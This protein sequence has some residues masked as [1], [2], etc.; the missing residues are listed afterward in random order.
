MATPITIP[1]NT[2]LIPVNVSSSYKTFTLPV[3]STNPG[4]MIIFKDMFGCSTNSTIRL[5]TIGLDRIEQSNVSSMVLSNNYGAWTFMNDGFT[6]WFQTN[7]YTNTF[8][9][10]SLF[11]NTLRITIG[12]YGTVN[13]V[14]GANVTT[15]VLSYYNA[16]SNS[17][18]VN[19]TVFGD[20]TPG[21]V[22]Y[23]WITYFPPGSGTSKV[24]APVQEGGTFFFNTLT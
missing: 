13:N 12:W 1:T 24:S 15:T 7:V 22:K 14:T 19:N 20:P 18:P 16:G 3:V 8:A 10:G 21:F 6:N 11:P 4:R 17:I 5:S 9:F 2:F 23:L